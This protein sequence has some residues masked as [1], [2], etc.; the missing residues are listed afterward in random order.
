MA[1]REETK[2]RLDEFAKMSSASPPVEYKPVAPVEHF[3]PQGAIAVQ[4]KR[5]EVEILRKLKVL[6]AAMGERWFY[7]WPVKDRKKGTVEWVEGPST[8]LAHELRRLFGNLDVDCRVED[9]GSSWIFYGRCI[10]LETGSSL[11]RP[12]QQRKSASK[13]G[14]EDDERR[15]D[16]AFQIGVSKATRNVIVN[17]LESYADFALH[18][19]KNALVDRIGEDIEKYR[20]QTVERVSTRVDLKRVEAVIGRPAKDWLASDISKVIAQMTAVAEGMALLDDVFPP[21]GGEKPKTVDLDQVIE[22]SP[23]RIAGDDSGESDPFGSPAADDEAAAHSATSSADLKREA[24]EKIITL[25][26][27]TQLSAEQRI[28]TLDKVRPDWDEQISD[29]EFVSKV[30]EHAYR[31]VNGETQPKEAKRYLLAMIK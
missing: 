13:I 15:L 28:E 4:V 25:A 23:G 21:L 17:A 1:T 3:R 26:I 29:I 12:F 20:E 22:S 24:V 27:D 14:G 6:A 7:R 9:L 8:K 19:A 18:E 2:S 11:T 16:I 31:V 10:D 5:D 30:F